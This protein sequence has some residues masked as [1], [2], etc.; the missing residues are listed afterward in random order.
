MKYWTIQT[1]D[2]IETVNEKGIFQP[3][4]DKSRYLSINS[5]LKDLYYFVLKAFNKINGMDLHGV[6]YAFAQSDGRRINSIKDIDE[7]CAF[8]K[9]KKAVIDGLW[10]MIAKGDVEIVELIY[11]EEFNPIFVDINDFQFLM[12]P[13]M[14]FPPYTKQSIDRICDDISKGQIRVSEFPSNVIQA[15]L[16]YIKTENIVNIYPIFDLD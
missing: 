13:I 12:P 3:D 14:Y 15:H 8:I 2:V 9:N 10:K 4:F 6:V 11:N 1:K 5:N 7:F 16:S